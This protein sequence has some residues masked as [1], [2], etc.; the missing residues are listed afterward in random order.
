MICVRWFHRRRRFRFPAKRRPKTTKSHGDPRPR[1]PQ[2][3]EKDNVPG[4]GWLSG[5]MRVPGA[6][7]ET[8]R[9]QCA[10]KNRF[11]MTPATSASRTAANGLIAVARLQTATAIEQK[12]TARCDTRSGNE[13]Q[14]LSMAPEVSPVTIVR[15]R[16]TC[17][18]KTP[19][20]YSP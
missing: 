10:G 7:P 16:R 14:S 5:P 18:P 2:D 15:L 3:A 19:A 4:A 8:P 17:T 11:S 1:G 6:P 20:A 13:R 12:A 9:S